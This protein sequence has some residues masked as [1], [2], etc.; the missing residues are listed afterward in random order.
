MSSRREHRIIPRLH[1]DSQ[2]EEIFKGVIVYLLKNKFTNKVNL[3]KHVLNVNVPSEQV[4]PDQTIPGNLEGEIFWQLIFSKQIHR[5][6]PRNLEVSANT[7]IG[8][9][10]TILEERN[11]SELVPRLAR[12]LQRSHV[13]GA[14]STA[15]A[16]LSRSCCTFQIS[17]LEKFSLDLLST[18]ACNVRSIPRRPQSRYIPS[19]PPPLF[20][21]VLK[22][23]SLGPE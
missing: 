17:R 5:H 4:I 18:S 21:S 22:I 13:K 20:L 6:S 19:L 7:H 10:P 12:R 2:A 16:A 1:V 11:T 8:D 15:A 3:G 23:Q 9:Q 14:T